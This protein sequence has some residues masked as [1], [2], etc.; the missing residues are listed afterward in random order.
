MSG[1]WISDITADGKGYGGDYHD[2][3]SNV[4]LHVCH[5]AMQHGYIPGTLPLKD[6]ADIITC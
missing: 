2:R 4:L 6:M 5:H 1:G 3:T